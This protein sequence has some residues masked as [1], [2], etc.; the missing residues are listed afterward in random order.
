MSC[1][2]IILFL[3]AHAFLLRCELKV[4]EK[5]FRL[6]NKYKYLKQGYKILRLKIS[7]KMFLKQNASYCLIKLV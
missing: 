5:K 4:S 6:L 2:I 1:S 7:Y 3:E